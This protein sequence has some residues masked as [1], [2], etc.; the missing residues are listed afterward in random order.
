MRR[1][2]MK[3]LITMAL[4]FIMTGNEICEAQYRY[5]GACITECLKQSKNKV[6]SSYLHVCSD[7][8]RH[9]IFV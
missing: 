2:K 4:L 7:A 3:I 8:C 6:D 5:N 9:R 1:S